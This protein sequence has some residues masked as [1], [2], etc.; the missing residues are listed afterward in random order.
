[1]IVFLYD[2]E[3]SVLPKMKQTNNKILELCTMC[4]HWS[5]S[6]RKLL[7]SSRVWVF[8]GVRCE[9][10]DVESSRPTWCHWCCRDCAYRSKWA[11]V[12]RWWWPDA[13]AAP[14]G[15]PPCR[16]KCCIPMAWGRVILGH[17]LL[18]WSAHWSYE[19]SY[20][21][22]ISRPPVDVDSDHRGQAPCED[23]QASP[24][25]DDLRHPVTFCVP[26]SISYD[27]CQTCIKF[28][29]HLTIFIT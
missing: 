18:V 4:N 2:R 20:E 29:Y 9:A 27:G 6:R 10:H 24:C 22:H 15:S 23:V 13:A 12:S 17:L 26:S 5:S 7:R 25:G 21:S 19:W 3:K 8:V 28:I 16:P 11:F 14:I 1:M